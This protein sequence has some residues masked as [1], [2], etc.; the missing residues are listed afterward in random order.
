ME[1]NWHKLSIREIFARTKSA[2]TGLT[3]AEAKK[4]L[5]E[6][7]PNILPREK[8]Y[9]KILLFF[10]QFNSPLIYILFA[11]VSVSFLI[12]HYSDAIFIVIVLLINTSVGFYQENKANASLRA[13][14][15]LV[16]VRA[17]VL[18]DGNEK[19]ID[20][21]K[22]V[23]GDVMLLKPG[24]K[25]P[26][27][28]RIIESKSLKVNEASLTGEWLASEKSDGGALPEKTPLP[29]RRNMVFMGTIV[30]EGW[31]RAEV[32][33]TGVGTQIGEIVSLL[34]ET[35][36]RHTPL[37]KKIRILSR[38]IGAFVISVVILVLAEG[39]FTEKNFAEI[40][41][42][43]VALAVSAVPAG[44]LPAITV[45][46]VFGMRRILKAKGL[47][48]K[49]SAN[50]T[51]GSVTVIATDKTG[52]LTEGKMKVSHIL[53]STK[54]L[55]GDGLNNIA[56]GENGNGKE[57]HITAL[58]V[59]TLATDAFVENPEAELENWI[60]RGRPTEQA[61]LLAGM[62]SGLNKKELEKQMP[63]IDR[64]TFDN[65]LKYSAAYHKISGKENVLYVIGAPEELIS[66]SYDMDIDGR[67]EKLGLARADALIGRLDEL[68]SKGLRVIASAYRHYNSETKYEK[69]SD[70]VNGLTLIGF[71]ALK[72]PLRPDAK[73]AIA[74]TKKA[75]IR[76]IIITGDHK[77]TAKTI[78]EEV[79]IHA[80]DENII[81]GVELEKM[82]DSELR[83]KVKST[84]IYARV[85]PKHKLQIVS[86][87]QENGE[88]VAMFGDGVNDAPAL[89][90]A[91]VGVALGSG[92]DVAK[93]VSDIVLLGDNFS[94]IVKA[95]E[96][97]RMIFE[98]I[99]KVFIYLIADDFSELVLFMIAMAMGLPLPLLPAQIL[100]INLVEDGLPDIALTTEQEIKG[101][102]EEKPR[103]PEGPIINKPEKAWMASI[104]VITGLV[105][106]LSF[107][108]IWKFTGDISKTRT[109]VFALMAVDS[110]TFAYN[111]RSLKRTV[112]RRDIFSN[113]FLN[114][115]VAIS[116]L[117]LLIGIYFSPLQTVL[118]TQSLYLKEWGLIFILAALEMTLI[119]ISKKIIFKER[120][121]RMVYPVSS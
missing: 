6:N 78:A 36:E 63:V 99:K 45:I 113:K 23:V 80:A 25:V 29:E 114:G 32:V 24:D 77:L 119:A 28:G 11:A 75:G 47:V 91:D 44:L 108:F 116:F 50:E 121:K 110:L 71:I 94:T 79:G 41:V 16:K 115:A 118:G 43:S 58:K 97:G 12:N 59:A 53:T 81:E 35:R 84:I 48:R 86:A 38:W 9:P 90:A 14:K 56:K 61:L 62:Q 98:N 92:T 105:A 74:L 10:S 21:E 70:L 109:I 3:S 22:L 93:E 13:L 39:Y 8:P 120:N 102:M 57:S 100:W 37:Q 82:V 1:K 67:K 95:V 4:R 89:K 30:E 18:R 33:S 104:F 69:L 2:K 66:K 5:K 76:A 72:D 60:V 96:Q 64:I 83:Q 51:L 27:D 17:W 55:L 68:T 20:S 106:F 15:K 49:L 88:V 101:I 7:G 87:L 42:A 85:S 107:F 26:A 65:Q 31:C 40:F 19:E 111:V 54:E 112:F 52:T 117:L 46:L 34:K 73:A 103:D